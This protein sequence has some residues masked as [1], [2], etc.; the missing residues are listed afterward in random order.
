MF[1]AT[2]ARLSGTFPPQR[3]TKLA[4][5]GAGKVGTVL[6]HVLLEN[7]VKIVAVIS[8]TRRSAAT[9]AKTLRCKNFSDSFSA[10]PEDVNLILIATPHE[11]VERVAG[12]IALLTN[13]SFRKLVVCHTSGMLTARALAP[14]EKKGATVFSFHPLQ[15]F[16][17]DFPVRKVIPSARGIYYGIDGTKKALHIAKRLARLLQGHALHIPPSKRAFYH[18]TCVV[19]SNHL[20]AMLGVVETM[21]AQFGLSEHRF[22][23]V[24]QPI[25]FSTLRNTKLSSPRKALTGPVARGGIQTVTDHFAAVKKFNP[26]LLPY[27]GTLTLQTVTLAR[28]KG[29][30]SPARARALERI[31]HSYTISRSKDRP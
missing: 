8:R 9:A 22:F 16:P 15:T 7:G 10:I 12:E 18:A 20:T 2:K 25:L 26:G 6:G 1:R 4:I 31:V 28:R 23:E 11:S 13:L 29:S 3:M 14:L 30:I 24:F 19:A 17:R 21:S 27:F 5:V